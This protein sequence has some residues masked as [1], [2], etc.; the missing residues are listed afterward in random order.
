MIAAVGAGISSCERLHR[1]LISLHVDRACRPEQ[2]G[3]DA[4]GW[5]LGTIRR[6][7]TDG[8]DRRDVAEN[9]HPFAD[10]GLL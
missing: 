8:G 7:A 1:C 10:A 6:F 5:P 3:L 2:Q 9:I 4:D